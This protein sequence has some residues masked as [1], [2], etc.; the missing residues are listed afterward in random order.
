MSSPRKAVGKLL[1]P[2][3]PP[4]RCTCRP[5]ATRRSSGGQIDGEAIVRFAI[6]RRHGRTP[7]KQTPRSLMNCDATDGGDPRLC[8]GARRSE[9]PPAGARP[10]G[11]HHRVRSGITGRRWR[12]GDVPAKAGQPSA[13]R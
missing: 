13:S 2:R 10:R 11:A 8:R 12:R 9:M 3:I 6:L 1:N 5:S 7:F 4:C